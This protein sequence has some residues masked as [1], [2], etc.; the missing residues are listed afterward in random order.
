MIEISTAVATDIGRL[1][2]PVPQPDAVSQGF[3]DAAARGELAIQH[4]VTCRTFQHPPRP[5][6]RTC[7]G[8]GLQFEPVSGRGRLWSW[9]VVHRSMLDGFETATPYTCI[10]VE[11]QEQKGLFLLSDLID[12]N[13]GDELTVGLPVRVVF[14]DKGSDGPT[15][16]QFVSNGHAGQP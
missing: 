3:W 9:T 5:L 1:T 13:F 11:L 16:P 15:L 10:V 7:G 6:C 8:T 14:P 4:C 2:R 12:R